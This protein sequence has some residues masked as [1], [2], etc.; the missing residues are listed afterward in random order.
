VDLAR[1]PLRL[2]FI[3]YLRK[4]NW[5]IRNDTNNDARVS[6]IDTSNGL[7]LQ[8]LQEFAE[9][10]AFTSQLHLV[11]DT[12]DSIVWNLTNSREYRCSSAYNTQTSG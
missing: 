7:S 3:Q 1:N 8:H 2:P 10:W 11:D 9:L 12:L 5:S 4:K 6:Q